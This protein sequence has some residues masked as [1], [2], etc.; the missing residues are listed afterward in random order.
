[1]KRDKSTC[2]YCGSTKHLTLDHVIP[3]SKGGKSSWDNVV[4]ACEKC[5]NRKSDRTPQQAGMTLKT[6]P[7][8]P[9]HPMV[10]FADQ[11]WREYKS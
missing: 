9:K 8:V 2:Q 10:A 7:K 3:T 6:I 11:F 5:N 4:T 1:M